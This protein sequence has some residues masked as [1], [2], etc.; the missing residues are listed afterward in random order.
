[1]NLNKENRLSDEREIFLFMYNKGGKFFGQY[2]I[3]LYI[4]FG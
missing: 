1:M 2:I 4:H 3:I